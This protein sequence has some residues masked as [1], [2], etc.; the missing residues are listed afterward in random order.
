VPGLM[1]LAQE[2]GSPSFPGCMTFVRATDERAVLA[3][4]GVDPDA[5]I[6][7]TAPEFSSTLGITLVRSSDWL[8]ALEIP[9]NPRGIRPEALRRLSVGAEV[10]VIA[11]APGSA[12][13]TRTRPR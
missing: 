3:G 6:P 5:A 2:P 4:L 13:D 12:R 10:V 9:V 8:V 1:W 7:P 11:A